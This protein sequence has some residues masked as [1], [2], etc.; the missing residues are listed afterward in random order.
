ML[1]LE[2]VSVAAAVLSNCAD[3]AFLRTPQTV[4]QWRSCPECLNPRA[5]LSACP[6]FSCDVAFQAVCGIL[7]HK[8]QALHCS[9]VAMICAQYA[10]A[11][12]AA[13]AAV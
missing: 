9:L 2:V 10:C 1:H 13:P 5:C 4:E 3:E 6:I 12:P 7:G 8:V 11:L